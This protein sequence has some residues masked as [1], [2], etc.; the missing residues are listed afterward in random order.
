MSYKYKNLS[1]KIMNKRVNISINF[2]V[3][4]S[5]HEINP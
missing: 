3:K 1:R 2:V 4:N 5:I